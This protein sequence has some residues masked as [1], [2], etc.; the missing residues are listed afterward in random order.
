MKVLITG[1]SGFVGSHLCRHLLASGHEV[2]ALVRTLPGSAGLSASARRDG[3]VWVKGDSRTDLSDHLHGVEAVIHSAGVAHR[4][5]RNPRD[6]EEMT[7]INAEWTRRIAETVAG[8]DTRLLVHISTIAVL[9]RT[10]TPAGEMLDEETVPA[11]VTPYGRSKLAA[12]AP[13]AAL[14]EVGKTGINL[15]PPLIYGSGAKGNWTR[16]V[17]MA[18]RPVPLP[19]R[20]VENRRS[21]LGIGNLCDLVGRILERSGDPSCSGEYHVVD[22][23]FFS[24]RQVIGTLREARG[25]T[26]NL[27]PCPPE[28]LGC[29]LRAAGRGA[30]ADSLLA[31]LRVDNDK[32]KRQFN[33]KPPRGT[34]EGMAESIRPAEETEPRK[35]F[36]KKSEL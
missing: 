30:L 33:W 32:V 16:L 17:R 8:S 22:D 6:E 2:A 4:P 20:S 14:A 11:P 3:P 7:K 26:A 15:R 21:F 13:V 1:A 27:L 10:R 31:D 23:G 34:L 18:A 36:P 12:E 28:L 35:S 19:F 25:H 5:P 9:G 29:A 24:L